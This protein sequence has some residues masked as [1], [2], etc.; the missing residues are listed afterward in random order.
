MN[1]RFSCMLPRHY[2]RFVALKNTFAPDQPSALHEAHYN[3]RRTGEGLSCPRADP[4]PRRSSSCAR[5][6][7]LDP[8]LSF[9]L[10]SIFVHACVPARARARARSNRRPSRPV[11]RHSSARRLAAS[12]PP[13]RFF[14]FSGQ[15]HPFSGH[16][17][18]VGDAPDSEGSEAPCPSC[19][20]VPFL[21]VLHLVLHLLQIK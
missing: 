4:G 6:A 10:P 12:P 11:P 16:G 5:T 9:L 13:L 19:P 14:R 2:V 7:P 1:L 8:S 15:K 18:G 20:P 21:V 3:L 17:C